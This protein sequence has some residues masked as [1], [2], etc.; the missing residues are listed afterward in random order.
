MGK[1]LFNIYFGIAFILLTIFGLAILPLILL[2]NGLVLKRGLAT[3]L[4]R[5]IRFYGWVIVCCIPF[6]AP[7]RV[8]YSSRQPPVPA[9]FVANHNSAI[10]PYL[11]G[12]IARENSFVTSWPFKIPLY[13]FFMKLAQY[14]NSA[15]GWDEVSKKCTALLKAGSSVTIWPEGHRSRDGKLGRFK[16]GA[17]AL[18]AETGHPIVPVCIIGSGDVLSPGS[19]LLTPGKVKLVILEPISPEM[20]EE[21]QTR[22]RNLRIKCHTAILQSL[23]DHGHFQVSNSEQEPLFSQ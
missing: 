14:A 18:S 3:G 8:E 2:I 12:A 6:R 1:L 15:D 11:F 9:I 22:I 23:E 16:N 19:R 5:S 7:V 10:D 13:S 4:R 17:F 20:H 21:K